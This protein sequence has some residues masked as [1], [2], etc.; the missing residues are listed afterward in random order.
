LV[1]EQSVLDHLD[2]Q[3]EGK[4]QSRKYWCY[5]EYSC[6][7]Y[8]F[9][10]Q[11]MLKMITREEEKKYFYLKTFDLFFCFETFPLIL[12]KNCINQKNYGC[13]FKKK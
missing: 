11:K 12:I 9:S 6:N 8:S 1:L 5:S 10:A 2:E 13:E 3:L 4:H 7:L